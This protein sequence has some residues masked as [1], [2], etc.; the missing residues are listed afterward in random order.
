MLRMLVGIVLLAAAVPSAAAALTVFACESEWAALAQELGKTRVRV[1][2]A[3]TARQDPHHIEA[4]PSLIARVRQAD[5][6]VCTGAELE[7]GWLPVLLRRAGNA[8]VQPGQAGY[9][10][11]AAVV[12]RL[13][14]PESVDRAMGD[15]HPSGNPHVHT[16]PDSRSQAQRSPVVAATACSTSRRA[17]PTL[18]GSV[19]PT[20]GTSALPPAPPPRV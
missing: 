17:A 4:R 1:F 16:D 5:L 14:V 7:I 10:E 6:V 20:W 8:K 11:A 18:A 12:E 3:T 9:F 19:P 15:V 13:D 2:A